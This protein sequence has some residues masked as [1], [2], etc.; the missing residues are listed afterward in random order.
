MLILI[1]PS[2][3]DL[4]GAALFGADLRDVALVVRDAQYTDHTVTVV[5]KDAKANEATRW[6]RGFDPTAAGVTVLPGSERRPHDGYVAFKDPGFEDVTASTPVG[7]ADVF[8][9]SH[10][11]T[12]SPT[13]TRGRCSRR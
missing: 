8:V 4:S 7:E 5:L 6:P 10:S 12:S 2:P 3:A 1:G 9:H 11:R 13:G